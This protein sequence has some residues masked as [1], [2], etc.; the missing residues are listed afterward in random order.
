MATTVFIFHP[1]TPVALENPHVNQHGSSVV[2]VETGSDIDL[3]Y[4]VL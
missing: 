1:V 3:S 2:A 4:W